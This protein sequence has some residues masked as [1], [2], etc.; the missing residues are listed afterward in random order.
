MNKIVL[1]VSLRF[2]SKITKYMCIAGCGDIPLAPAC[3][4]A[5]HG[6][7]QTFYAL[8]LKGKQFFIKT[9]ILLFVTLEYPVND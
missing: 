6:I 8:T 2:I 7:A 3:R 9:L 1:S 4:I 5:C